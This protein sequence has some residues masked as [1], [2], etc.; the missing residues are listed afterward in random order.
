M[1]LRWIPFTEC[2]RRPVKGI[3]RIMIKKIRFFLLCCIFLVSCSGKVETADRFGQG[4]VRFGNISV[5]IGH[6]GNGILYAHSKENFSA[7]TVEIPFLD[8][9]AIYDGRIYRLGFASDGT[10]EEAWSILCYDLQESY[11]KAKTILE[12]T[13]IKNK[14]AI[15]EAFIQEG[16]LYCSWLTKEDAEKHIVKD[17]ESGAAIEFFVPSERQVGAV[18]ASGYYYPDSGK[19]YYSSYEAEKE[20]LFFETEGQVQSLYRD[21]ENLCALIERDGMISAAII[22]EKGILQKE[23]EGLEQ[24]EGLQN[25]HNPVY[26]R[27]KDGI[28]Y[29]ILNGRMEGTSYNTWLIRA[30]LKEGT[31]ENCGGWYTP[32][33]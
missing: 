33:T 27:E 15:G 30:I 18:T 31:R 9:C 24:V 3:R 22:N 19:I 8:Y 13:D 14:E 21:G 12:L 7:E 1:R 20:E 11:D 10:T 2:L 32:Q 6:D 16:L 26:L 17:M 4:S 28:L 29:Y 5:E 23:Y 25:V